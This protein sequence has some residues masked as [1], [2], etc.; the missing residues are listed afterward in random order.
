MEIFT[1]EN[2]N[3]SKLV[4]K[5]ADWIP[6]HVS[7][8]IIVAVYAILDFFNIIR[9]SKR[10]E[11]ME[12]N[13]R[14][15][16]MDGSPL[17][18]GYIE[19]QYAWKNIA[20][21]NTNMA[22][23]GCEIM[24]VYNVLKARNMGSGPQLAGELIAAFEKRGAALKGVIGS[25]PLSIRAFLKKKGIQ[26]RLIWRDDKINEDVQMAIVTLYN[27]KSSLLYQIHTIAFIR[28]E[29]KGF[30]PHNAR[31]S[32]PGYASLKEAVKAVGSNPKTICILEIC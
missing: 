18:D 21:G 9:K 12:S 19:N 30:V 32:E 24:A 17:N 25:S 16:S 29:E 15:L 20:F 10:D 13:I 27:D 14:Q 8:K 5:L 3:H 6:Q 28:D 2:Q 4:K 26:T 11:H 23:S 22:A 1:I 31:H 7:G